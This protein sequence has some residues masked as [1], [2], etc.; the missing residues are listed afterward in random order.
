MSHET[1]RTRVVW[2]TFGVQELARRS[3]SPGADQLHCGGLA[4]GR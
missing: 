4:D 2:A 1:R 3:G